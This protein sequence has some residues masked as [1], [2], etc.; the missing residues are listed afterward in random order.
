MSIYKVSERILDCVA[1]ESA[2]FAGIIFDCDGVLIDATKSYDFTVEQC[3]NAF[4]ASLGVRLSD[5][6]QLYH[7]LELLRNLGTFNNDWDSVAV[8][9]AYLFKTSN[10]DRKIQVIDNS[11]PLAQRLK[12]LESNYLSSGSSD[13]NLLRLD[14]LIQFL[15]SCP[16]GMTR[17]EMIAT[18]IQEKENRDELSNF[19]S[20]P[21]P[22]SVGL[23]ATFFDEAMYGKQ[24]FRETYDLECATTRVSVPGN[25]QNESVLVGAEA[26]SELSRLCAGNLGIITGRPKVPTVHTLG[27]LFHEFFRR[28]EICVFTGENLLDIDEVKPSPRPMFRVG[29]ALQDRHSPILYIGDSEEDLLMVE[30]TND[31]KLLGDQRVLFVAIAPTKER[32][33]FF[34]KRGSENV[35]CIVSSVNEVWKALLGERL[36][37]G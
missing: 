17:E 10:Y 15:M 3:A 9:V 1:N 34:E 13:L 18:L 35:E 7:V 32:A 28:Q 14:E 16:T 30:R 5:D 21:A 22:V 29:E 19:L 11:A 33:Q 25:I 37:A 6:G 31:S 4:G 12:A 2:P 26:L 27:R 20:Y 23:L 8:I 24:L 36:W